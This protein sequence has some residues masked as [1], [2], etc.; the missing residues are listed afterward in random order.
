MRQSFFAAMAVFALSFAN[1]HAKEVQDA[2]K[3][4]WQG[5]CYQEN[6]ILN[7]I[8][9]DYAMTAANGSKYSYK[10]VESIVNSQCSLIDAVKKDD[11]DRAYKIFM[12]S[13]AGSGAK[14]KKTPPAQIT[15]KDKDQFMTMIKRVIAGLPGKL[16]VRKNKSLR[17][18]S[19]REKSGETH[20]EVSFNTGG[21]EQKASLVLIRSGKLHL[22]RE[23][24]EHS[25]TTAKG[26]RRY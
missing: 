15:P 1:A 12:D 26:Q 9:K 4:Y 5:Y 13:L 3:R 6:S 23:H 7:C 20:A 16:N 2:V 24:R 25:V 17:I 14:V 11:F 8:T 19:I 10:D 22:V 18:V 21:S